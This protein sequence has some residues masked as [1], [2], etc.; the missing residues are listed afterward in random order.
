M[1]VLRVLE[2]FA[3]KSSDGF[4]VPL[5]AGEIVD[6]THPAVKGREHMF[7][8][9]EATAARSRDEVEQ[10]TAAPGEKRAVKKAAAKPKT[11]D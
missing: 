6:S 2:A 10:A 11:G 9:V 7:E 4:L 3:Y 1:A 5:G 8:P